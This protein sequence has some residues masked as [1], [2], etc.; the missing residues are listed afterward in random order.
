MKASGLLVKVSIFRY[1]I[2]YGTQHLSQIDCFNAEIR[3]T[4]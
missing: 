4:K 1:I 3:T 2:I